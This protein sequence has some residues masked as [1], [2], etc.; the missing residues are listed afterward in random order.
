[1][2]FTGVLKFPNTNAFDGLAD[3]HV[4]AVKLGADGGP[5]WAISSFNVAMGAKVFQ[6]NVAADPLGNVALSGT[7]SGPFM[8][9]NIPSKTS[10]YHDII[11]ANLAR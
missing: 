7:L 8:L 9:G 11:V 5:Q 6:A 3:Q 2:M 10:G 1:M 4:F